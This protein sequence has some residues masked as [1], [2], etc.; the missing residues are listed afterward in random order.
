M[1]WCSVYVKFCRFWRW[2]SVAKPVYL[3]RPVR[4]GTRL[5]LLLSVVIGWLLLLLLLFLMKFY[6]AERQLS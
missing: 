5:L 3:R 2:Q 1:G 6:Q 4:A